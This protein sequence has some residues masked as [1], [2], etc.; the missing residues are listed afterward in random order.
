MRV[1]RA[2]VGLLCI[3]AMALTGCG[4]QL[5]Y[6]LPPVESLDGTRPRRRRSWT[7]RDSAG[8]QPVR[9]VRRRGRSLRRWHRRVRRRRLWRRIRQRR[10][11]STRPDAC[12]AQMMAGNQPSMMP[13]EHGSTTA[14]SCK[15]A[16]TADVRPIGC[17]DAC[18]RR[19]LRRWAAAVVAA[20]VMVAAVWRLWLRWR[21]RRRR[22]LR[23]CLRLADHAAVRMRW[24]RLQP[25]W[26]RRFVARLFRGH[27]TP[28][29]PGD[30]EAGAGGAMMGPG[31]LADR[32]PRRRRRAGHLG[33]Q[34]LR[35]VRLVRRS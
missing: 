1:E 32:V 22:L 28:T 26:R 14:A 17:G 31:H 29:R 2:L 3:T 4:G 27:G 13:T 6:N 30:F 9:H 12:R 34:R 11:E 25:V 23:R 5:A 8:R 20:A 19:Q 21:L 24:R 33:R 7:R 18:C 16:L 35:H 10:G 15:P